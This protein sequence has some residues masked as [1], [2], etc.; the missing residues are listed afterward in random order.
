MNTV[1]LEM[2]WDMEPQYSG[3]SE[4]SADRKVAS[5]AL[6]RQLQAMVDRH[7]E[8]ALYGSDPDLI[9]NPPNTVLHYEDLLKSYTEANRL[10]LVVSQRRQ[11]ARSGYQRSERWATA[12]SPLYQMATIT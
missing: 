2:R 7:L 8:M 9:K 5:L 10:S 4:K 12:L 11:L 1:T 6:S 3:L